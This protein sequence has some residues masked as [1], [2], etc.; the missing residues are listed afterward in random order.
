MVLFTKSLSGNSLVIWDAL[1]T[2]KQIAN[3]PYQAIS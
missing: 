2:G 1:S 3:H